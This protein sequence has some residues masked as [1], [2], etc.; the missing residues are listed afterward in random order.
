MSG[1]SA[2]SHAQG[3]ADLTEACEICMAFLTLVVMPTPPPEYF[4]PAPHPL[5]FNFN[6]PRKCALFWGRCGELL[7]SVKV[8]VRDPKR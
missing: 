7:I 2:G 3:R 4:I 1:S 5:M 6:I 8:M